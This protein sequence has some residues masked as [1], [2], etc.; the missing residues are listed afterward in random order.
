M[1]YLVFTLM[2]AAALGMMAF[3]AQAFTNGPPSSWDD[4]T[5]GDW[6]AYDNTRHL[7]NNADTEY[8][9]MQTIYGPQWNSGE[10]D[11]DDISMGGAAQWYDTSP[12]WVY[13]D[14]T[15]RQGLVG[16]N[17]LQGTT[18]LSGCITFHINN[19]D[20]DNPFKWVWDEIYYYTSSNTANPASILHQLYTG[21]PPDP[22]NAYVS[23]QNLVNIYAMNAPDM[24]W[25]ENLDGEIL[26]NPAYEEIIIDFFVPMG[27]E[28][29]IDSFEVATICFPEPATLVLLVLGG[30]PLFRRRN[31]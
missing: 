29:Y 20:N 9:Y 27:E 15:Q 30:V 2:V 28:A 3:D 10:W 13:E 18:N 31:K 7:K 12:G 16:I 25:H 26:P 24:G 1:K 4:V 22:S 23:R 21:A 8:D 6:H 5:G 11:C 14:N 19:Y 17:N